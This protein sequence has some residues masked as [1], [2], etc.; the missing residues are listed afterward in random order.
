MRCVL[1]Q[2]EVY[3]TRKN[4]LFL[5]HLERKEPK[6]L[7]DFPFSPFLSHH[8]SREA[9]ENIKSQNSQNK[10][11]M[12]WRKHERHQREGSLS[13]TL[14]HESIRNSNLECLARRK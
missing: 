10:Q 7:S 14:L 9:R 8:Q 11:W 6:T 3:L 4:L 13:Q 1:P 5:S 12:Q 2:R